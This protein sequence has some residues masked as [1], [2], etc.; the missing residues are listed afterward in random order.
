MENG[1]CVGRICWFKS[2]VG[3]K[4]GKQLICHTC[5]MSDI[6]ASYP[7]I[8]LHFLILFPHFTFQR[9]IPKVKGILI[10]VQ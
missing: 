2:G 1:I 7:T 9:S 10:T 6:Y 3:S 8:V 4:V 5:R